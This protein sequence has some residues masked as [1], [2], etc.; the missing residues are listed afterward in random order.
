MTDIGISVNRM[1]LWTQVKN[2]WTMASDVHSLHIHLSSVTAMLDKLDWPPLEKRR[3]N[4]RLTVMFKIVDGLV[5][6]PS[7]H[8][9]QADSRTKANHIYK[10]KTI[11]SSSAAYKNSFFPRTIPQWNS[12]DK[13]TAEASSLSCFKNGLP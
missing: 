1:A 10:F 4:Q 8:L 3:K 9:V 11:S 12:L 13:D 2:F 6:V 7:S 5:A